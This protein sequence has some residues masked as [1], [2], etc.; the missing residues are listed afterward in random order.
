MSK[1][2]IVGDSSQQCLGAYS[3]IMAQSKQVNSGK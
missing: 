3:E 2:S 1:R